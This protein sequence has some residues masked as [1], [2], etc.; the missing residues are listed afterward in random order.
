MQQ[1]I[2]RGVLRLLV[3]VA[4]R[5]GDHVDGLDVA[6]AVPGEHLAQ[7]EALEAAQQVGLGDP[8]VS[9]VGPDVEDLRLRTGLADEARD[10][11]AVAGVGVE[12]ADHV[13]AGAEQLGAG[14]DRVDADRQAEHLEVVLD[15]VVEPRV[16]AD[17]GVEH[18]DD[19]TR[20]RRAQGVG[21]LRLGAEPADRL[22]AAPARLGV[23]GD[24]VTGGDRVSVR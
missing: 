7:G 8:A 24:A 19:R 13:L 9:A 4:E 11:R 3:V 17:A 10:E 5:Q 16:G 18:G 21:R 23:L 2:E 14:R 12:L 1:Q 20:G 6:E 15:H 22:P